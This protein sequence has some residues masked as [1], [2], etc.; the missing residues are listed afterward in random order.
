MSMKT[1]VKDPGRI[2]PRSV[3]G[4]ERSKPEV[5]KSLS[6]AMF[7]KIVTGGFE[8]KHVLLTF[9]AL[10][11]ALPAAIHA[12]DKKPN[13]IF[14]LFDDLGYGEPQ[15]FRNDSPFK[16]PNLDRLAREGMRF[17]DAHSAS[18]VCTPTLGASDG[19]AC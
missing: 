13:I 19:L 8:M 9:I 11:L 2:Q 5:K 4:T 10:L 7:R 12:A 18:S 1:P 6:S 16:M 3:D 14:I 15:S 17:T